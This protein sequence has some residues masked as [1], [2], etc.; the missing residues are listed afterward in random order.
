[1]GFDHAWY[2]RSSLFCRR[3]GDGEKIFDAVTSGRRIDAPDLVVHLRPGRRGHHFQ[4]RPGVN[5]RYKTFYGR[6]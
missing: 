4:Q 2:K 6:N 3:V 5:Q 1:M